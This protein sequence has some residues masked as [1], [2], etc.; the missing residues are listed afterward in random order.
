MTADNVNGE[1]QEMV[2]RGTYYVLFAVVVA[3]ATA[4]ALGA[5]VVA[6]A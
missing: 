4:L 5:Q 1:D 3:M 6:A 2:G